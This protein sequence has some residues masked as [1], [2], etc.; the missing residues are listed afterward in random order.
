MVALTVC[1][2]AQCY[3]GT[4]TKKNWFNCQGEEIISNLFAYVIDQALLARPIKSPLYGKA[5]AAAAPLEGDQHEYVSVAEG[6]PLI[7][8]S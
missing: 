4:L 3:C 1:L 5:A 7:N 6:G 8:G 2:A